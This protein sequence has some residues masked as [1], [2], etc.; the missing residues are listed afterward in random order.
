MATV[1]I[2]LTSYNHAKFL[3]EAIDSVINQTFTDWELFIWDDVSSD[4]SW[5]IIQSYSDTRIKA[6]RNDRTRRYLYAINNT[7]T[8]WATGQYIAIHHSDDGWEP[9]KLAEQVAYLDTHEDVGAVFTHIQ[10]IDENNRLISNDWFNQPNRKRTEWLRLLFLNTNKLCHPSAL[11]RKT[12]YIN[13]GLY[14]LAHAQNDDAEMWTR[15]LMNSE[16]HIIPKKL[17]RHRLFSDNSSV[18]GNK[19]SV[20]SRLQFEWFVQKDNYLKLSVS[21]IVSMFPEAKQWLSN[22]DGVSKFL[23]AMVAVHYGNSLGTRLFGLNLLYKLLTNPLDAE[24]ISQRH[25]FDYLEFFKLT[26]DRDIFLS[27]VPPVMERKAREEEVNGIHAFLSRS[28]GLMTR[29]RQFV[30]QGNKN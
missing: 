21:E 5:D 13:E 3:R 29:I 9:E 25:N 30:T 10:V 22:G 19:P 28:T 7:I 12:A 8:D 11:V 24:A 6:F 2:V 16:I 20:Q 26:G 23:L 18:S 14:K 17:T 1:S 27:H 15:L 4:H